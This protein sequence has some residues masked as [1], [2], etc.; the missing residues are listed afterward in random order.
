[1]MGVFLFFKKI[2]KSGPEEKV[3]KYKNNHCFFGYYDV[4]PFSHDNNLILSLVVNSKLV[5]PRGKIKAKLAYFNLNN[6][7]LNFFGETDTWCWQ[8]GCRLQWYPQ[9][10]E[11]P[12][13]FYNKYLGDR[14]GGV[15]QN[16]F[17]KKIIK[18][19]PMPLYAI[20]ID[21]KRGLSLDFFKLQKNRPGYGYYFTH[22]KKMN[23]EFLNNEGIWFY[24]FDKNSI[25]LIIKIEDLIE[26]DKIDS[27]NSAIHYINHLMF[28]PSG[29]RF[30]FIHLWLKDGKRYSRLIT[31]DISGRNIKVLNNSGLVSHYNWK[32]DDEILVYCKFD[33]IMSY[34]LY[35]DKNGCGH[36]IGEG[37]LEEDGHPS[38][39]KNNKN[40]ITDTYPNYKGLQKL[41]AFNL[42]NKKLSIINS[43][44]RPLCFRGEVRCD[45]HPRISFDNKYI[46]VDDVKKDKRV[47]KVLKNNFYV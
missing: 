21:G 42:E 40:I 15:I 18:E 16:V 47:L 36:K 45:L 4:G 30:L 39:T 10:G 27:M 35:N 38:F 13:V 17:T 33:N 22:D 28:N 11:T 43:Y 9:D 2:K 12:L 20:S 25:D 7:N 1:M 41:L 3:L 24:N 44:F 29:N 6:N 32:N 46:C 23:R 5:S 34:V 14:Y 31:S 19:I 37:I 26:I 8:Q